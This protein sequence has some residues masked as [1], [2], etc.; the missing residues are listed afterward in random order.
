M[1][2][3]Y[4][5]YIFIEYSQADQPFIFQDVWDLVDLRNGRVCLQADQE[6]FEYPASR[7]GLF[8][9]WECSTSEQLCFWV[10]PSDPDGQHLWNATHESALHAWL[11]ALLQW[12]DLQLCP[13]ESK[14]FCSAAL[15]TQNCHP[16]VCINSTFCP[17]HLQSVFRL[18]NDAQLKCILHINFS[19]RRN[20]TLSM[21]PIWM[22]RAYCICTTKEESSSPASI[23]MAS[24]RWPFLTPRGICSTWPGTPMGSD[25]SSACWPSTVPW[26]SAQ[27]PK[28]SLFCTPC[29]H[30]NIHQ[31]LLFSFQDWLTLCTIKSSSKLIGLNLEHMRPTRFYPLEKLSFW[32]ENDSIP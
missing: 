21:R 1:I 28:V 4:Y 22:E 23:W 29:H 20:L 12:R 5:T 31:R 15:C 6:L 14:S 3:N 10:P 7:A 32:Q 2:R 25:L 17:S 19:F 27:R 16:K 11:L 13:G 9:H 24:L 26:P 18:K 8:P 30:L